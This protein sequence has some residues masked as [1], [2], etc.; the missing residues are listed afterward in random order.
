MITKTLQQHEDFLKPPDLALLIFE[1]ATASDE[2][3]DAISDQFVY[4]NNLVPEV[5]L[6]D[7]S[8][9]VESEI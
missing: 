2:V 5:N 3:F 4:R 9:F 1:Y 7:E 8:Y 6:I